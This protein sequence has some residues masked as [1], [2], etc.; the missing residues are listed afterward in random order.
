M[1]CLT[2]IYLCNC[3]TYIASWLCNYAYLQRLEERY[4]KRRME[5]ESSAFIRI[6]DWEDDKICLL[7]S[8]KF[9]SWTICHL[10]DDE[11]KL[12]SIIM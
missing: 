9:Q 6:F 8:E 4:V 3:Y 1:F 10:N 11:V 7:Y 12:N 2:F 5:L